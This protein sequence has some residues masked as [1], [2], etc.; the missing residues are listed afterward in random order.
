MALLLCSA[1]VFSQAVRK[2]SNDFLNIGVGAR[3]LGYEQCPGSPA[4]ND[5]TPPYY[6]P[7]GL[8]NI[9][10]KDFQIGFMHCEYFAVALPN[11][12]I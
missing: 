12:I 5:C 7:A 1:S 3:G 9:P 11:M 10:N 8:V 2:Y 4:A 6:N